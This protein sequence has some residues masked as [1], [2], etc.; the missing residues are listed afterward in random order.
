[1][2][3]FEPDIKNEIIEIHANKEG[4]DKLVGYLQ[5]LRDE[6]N[7]EHIHLMTHEWGGCELTSEKQN[8]DAGFK[9]V[10]HVKLIKW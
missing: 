1:M 10:N 6:A 4:I 9:L 3:T 2:L 8:H 7:P 5:S